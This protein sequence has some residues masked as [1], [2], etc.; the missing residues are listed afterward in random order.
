MTSEFM[1]YDVQAA[2]DQKMTELMG[3]AYKPADKTDEDEN[4]NND[5][6]AE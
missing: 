4:A 2:Y 1:D 6:T 3:D 5:S